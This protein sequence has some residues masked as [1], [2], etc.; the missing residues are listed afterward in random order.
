MKIVTIFAALAAVAFAS[1]VIE[2]TD[3]NFDEKI[4]SEEVILV[5]FYA[6]W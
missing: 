2:L 5:E 6:P 4:N 1:D 3:S